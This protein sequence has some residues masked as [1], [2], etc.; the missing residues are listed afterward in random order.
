MAGVS[1][2]Y[3]K[4]HRGID[5]GTIFREQDRK[6]IKSD[7]DDYDRYGERTTRTPHLPSWRSRDRSKTSFHASNS[8]ASI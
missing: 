1:V 6:A 8:L 5:H 3:S 4:N 7:Q 2:T